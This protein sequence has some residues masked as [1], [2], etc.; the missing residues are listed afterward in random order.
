LAFR[1]EA[2]YC[3]GC[4]TCRIA[5]DDVKARLGSGDAPAKPSFRR[6]TEAESGRYLREGAGY[7]A[8]VR[9]TYRSETCRHCAEP[10]CLAACAL[11]AISKREKDGVVLIDASRCSSCGRC[12]AACP[13]GAIS[14]DADTGVAEKCDFCVDRIGS[15]LEPACVAACPM[16]ALHSGFLAERGAER[17]GEEEGAGGG[18]R[19]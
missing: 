19:P 16:R 7:V 2:Q 18:G 12:V 5:C 11:G 8:Q 13:F 10:A 3:T 9:I 4:Q 15:G 14:L 17:G 6:V 1:F